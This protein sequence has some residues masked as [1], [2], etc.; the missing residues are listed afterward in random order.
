MNGEAAKRMVARMMH[1]VQ[2]PPADNVIALGTLMEEWLETV[3]DPK[4]NID[5]GGG[6]FGYDL[7]V[8]LDGKRI[9]IH[10]EEISDDLRGPVGD[11]VRH[12]R[13][14]GWIEADDGT[15]VWYHPS[16]PSKKYSMWSEVVRACIDLDAAERSPS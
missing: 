14:K 4:S 7:V 6:E 13:S 1:N 15:T 5:V 2:N 10:I 11:V 8:E 16:N 12:L 9:E 3:K